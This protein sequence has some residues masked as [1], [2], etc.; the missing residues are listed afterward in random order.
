MDT[1]KKQKLITFPQAADILRKVF[2]YCEIR[3]LIMTISKISVA[4]RDSSKFVLNEI[5]NII[6][7]KYYS[8]T[9]VKDLNNIAQSV[10]TNSLLRLLS[11]QTIFIT[12]GFVSYKL[13]LDTKKWTRCSDTR[14]DRGHFA[15]AYLS[16]YVYAIG[17][18]NLIATGTV[19]R[20]NC[21]TNTW[22]QVA[23]MPGHLQSVA[24]AVFQK[25]LY[26]IG[27]INANT[28]VPS[29]AIHEYNEE[30]DCWITLPH[31]INFA[32]SR[33][34]VIEYKGRIW[35]AGGRLHDEPATKRYMT[36]HQL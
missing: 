25:K 19:E 6:V 36:L 16:G 24:A 14:R 5:L 10:S 33:H 32:R 17:T 21:I 13:E 2:G 7:D 29:K 18:L 35:I 28:N 22:S 1:T 12:R 34:S 8:T 27:G 31:S 23:V 20:Y 26:V 3:D 9:F 30:N 11:L 15:I 4:F